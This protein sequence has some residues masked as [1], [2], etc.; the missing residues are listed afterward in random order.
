MGRFFG[1][2]LGWKHTSIGLGRFLPRPRASRSKPTSRKM[3]GLHF[4]R[5]GSTRRLRTGPSLDRKLSSCRLGWFL[6][7]SKTIC[8]ARIISEMS[9]ESTSGELL[10]LHFTG[11]GSTRR[12]RTD[13][14]GVGPV[15]PVTLG[16]SLRQ[17]PS[18]STT[19]GM[20]PFLS[21]FRGGSRGLQVTPVPSSPTSTV[22]GFPPSPA[23]DP[24]FSAAPAH[25]SATV[26]KF[27][28]LSPLQIPQPGFAPSSLDGAAGLGE[29][30]RSSLP[31]VVSKPFQCYY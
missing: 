21:S 11:G 30:L 3:L 9:S 22:F 17:I 10:G 31:M 16:C 24:N 14:V 12:S 6:P 20:A 1:S 27:I 25:S 7:N 19:S 29:K 8:S 2:G 28:P 13:L 23:L 26:F 18:S 5:G 15:S 4:I